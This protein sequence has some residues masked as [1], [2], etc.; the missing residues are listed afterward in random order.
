MDKKSCR[1]NDS[2]NESSYS[3]LAFHL[4]GRGVFVPVWYNDENRLKRAVLHK[5]D[6]MG[7][8]QSFRI[9]TKTVKELDEKQKKKK[10]C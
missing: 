10:C 8:T 3:R 6:K 5:N 9:T 2:D 7:K 1:I 4:F